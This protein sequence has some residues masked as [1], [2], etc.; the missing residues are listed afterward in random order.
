MSHITI[1]QQGAVA[2]ITLNRP[3]VHNAFD[4]KLIRELTIALIDLEREPNVRALVLAG[5][6]PSFSAGADMV[7]MRRM[8][9]A[10]EE[11]NRV[12]AQ[13]LAELMRTLAF[14]GKPTV[15]RVHGSAF[16]GGVGLIACCD[17]ALAS[18]E[19]KFGLTEVKLGLVPAVI[20]PYVIDAIGARQAVRLFQTAETFDA[21]RA[22]A[23]GLVH[24][25]VAPTELDGAVQRQLDL[26][27][28]AGPQAMREAKALAQRVAG[29][30]EDRRRLLDEENAALIARLRVSREG[31]EGLSAF[32]DKRKPDWISIEPAS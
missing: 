23:I 11:D 4:D 31:Q 8:A 25:V 17:V 10:P 30:V 21:A 5:S 9:G 32:L 2:T 7:W 6:G 1:T 22:L 20:S 19:A 24:E 16:G 3:E 14:L 27:A 26:L 29:R 13:R 28:K 15:A 12:D 18:S